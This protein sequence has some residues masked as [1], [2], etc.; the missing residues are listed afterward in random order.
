ML[1]TSFEIGT[2]RRLT[3]DG[4]GTLMDTGEA[5]F[6]GGRP[7]NVFCAPGGMSGIVITRDANQIRSFTILGLEAVNTRTLSGVFGISGLINPVGDRVFTRS[8]SKVDI[9]GYHSTTGV[10]G[11]APRLMI[12]IAGTT[13]YFGMDQMALSP[14][15]STLYVSQPGALNVYDTSTG[16]LLTSVTTTSID[17]PTGVCFAPHGA[18]AVQ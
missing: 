16:A 12:P 1:V 5:L 13:T 4:T 11:A 10:L 18:N 7:N 14:N 8:N 3:I 2:V 9:F 17:R 6:S 15:G